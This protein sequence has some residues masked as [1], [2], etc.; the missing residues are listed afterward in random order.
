M[1][2]SD[3]KKPVNHRRFISGGGKDQ[4]RT[5]LR[6]HVTSLYPF[7]NNQNV[8]IWIANAEFPVPPGLILRLAGWF[9]A[10]GGEKLVKAI[11][12]VHA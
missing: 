12:I 2:Q 3:C 5:A 9:Q 6:P 8:T 11:D 7:E 4:G 1:M 10:F